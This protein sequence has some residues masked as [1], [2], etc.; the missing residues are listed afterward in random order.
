MIFLLPGA[1]DHLTWSQE[2]PH[3]FHSREAVWGAPSKASSLVSDQGTCGIWMSMGVWG[4]FRLCINTVAFIYCMFLQCQDLPGSPS[5]SPFSHIESYTG[6]SMDPLLPVGETG[7]KQAADTDYDVTQKYR[8]ER[9]KAHV[10]GISILSRTLPPVPWAIV[11]TCLFQDRHEER[12]REPRLTLRPPSLAAPCTP[13]Q[14]WHHQPE[15]LIFES[16]AYEASVCF[17]PWVMVFSLNINPDICS[18]YSPSVPGFHAHQGAA[19][20][21]VHAGCLCQN[22]GMWK[23]SSPSLWNKALDLFLS[24]PL[25]KSLQFII[26]LF[27]VFQRSTEQMK[28]VPT[29]VLSITYKGVK[30]ID[31]AYKVLYLPSM[32]ISPLLWLEFWW[33]VTKMIPVLILCNRIPYQTLSILIL[34][35]VLV[36]NIIAE[37]E[38]RNIS[39]AAQDPEDLCT[40]AYITKDLQTSH[41]YCHVFSTVDVVRTP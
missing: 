41:H 33:C 21:W 12:H 17:T 10:C 34:L 30:F 40:F 16:C 20:Y 29:I 3:S 31:A 19:R 15:K 27:F 38:I 36:Q 13:V 26:G 11:L 1:E 28:K 39:C 4:L 14:N 37:H 8:S 35:L 32:L 5:S 18:F 6:R 22:A 23:V 25:Y 24:E 7:K 9:H 2:T